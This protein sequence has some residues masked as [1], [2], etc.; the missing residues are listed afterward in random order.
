MSLTTTASQ[1]P[2]NQQV[3]RHSFSHNPFCS[4]HSTSANSLRQPFLATVL[5]A[6]AP[7]NSPHPTPAIKRIGSK[8]FH[9][10]PS[11]SLS[12]SS[13]CQITSVTSLFPPTLEQPLNLCPNHK[14]QA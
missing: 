1:P 3:G 8:R 12:S 7:T 6:N 13:T 11:L 14:P 2:A 5:Q 10:K 4:R 9:Q